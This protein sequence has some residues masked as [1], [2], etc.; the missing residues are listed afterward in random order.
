M[1][2]KALLSIMLI[3]VFA[4]YSLADVVVNMSFDTLGYDSDGLTSD[5]QIAVD[6]SGNGYHGFYGGGS[7][8]AIINTPDGLGIDTSINNVYVI[9]R[10]GRTYTGHG[11]PSVSD[12]VTATSPFFQLEAANNYTFEALLKWDPTSGDTRHGIMGVPNYSDQFW[13]RE[14]NGYLQWAIGDEGGTNANHFASDVDISALEADGQ[15]HHLALVLDRTASE[16]RVLCRLS[17]DLH[18]H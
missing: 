14:N 4:G 16:M 17:V 12:P 10:P 15:W 2:M 3:L 5:G 11:D 6:Q 7:G 13:V 1:K 8:G 9:A 18:R